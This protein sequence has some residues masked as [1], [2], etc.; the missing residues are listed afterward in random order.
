MELR[1]ALVLS[2]GHVTP[3]DLERLAECAL[4]PR[5]PLACAVDA[6]GAWADTSVDDDTAQQLGAQGFSRSFL[7]A[8]GYAAAHGACYLRLDRDADLLEDAAID[9]HHW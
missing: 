5:A 8:L 1:T 4:D 2:T 3:E 9:V 7:K 6:H